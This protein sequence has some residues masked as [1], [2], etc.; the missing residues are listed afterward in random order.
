MKIWV[1]RTSP[2]GMETAAILS[3]AGHQVIRVPVLDVR[4]LAGEPLLSAP[5]AIVFTSRNGVRHHPRSAALLQIPVFAV[6]DRTAG[7]ASAAGYVDVRSAN[8]NVGD[9]QRLILAHLLPPARI[10][11]F[12]ARDTAGDLRGFLRRFGYLADRRMVYA[13]QSIALR[14]LL[15][16]RRTLNSIDGIVV[17]SPRAADRVARVLAG[18]GWT[19]MIWCISEACALRLIDV[20]GAELHFAGRPTD[21]ALLKMV[22]GSATA[23]IPAIPGKSATNLN[24]LPAARPPNPANDDEPFSGDPGEETDDNPPPAA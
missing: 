11:H 5:D 21:A 10:V 6:G 19:G 1:T 23:H 12:G 16:V 22:L 18:T 4:P 14:W 17:H 7:E 13:A 9:L 24:S 20:P 15:S 8:G 2:D 3:S